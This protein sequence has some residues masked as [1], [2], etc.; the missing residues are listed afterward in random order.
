MRRL[1]EGYV[2]SR[3]AFIRINTIIRQ[4]GKAYLVLFSKVDKRPQTFEL[5]KNVIA[6]KET[7]CEPKRNLPTISF[8]LIL[9]DT[10]ILMTFPRNNN[11]YRSPHRTDL[12]FLDIMRIP[13]VI[14]GRSSSHIF[15]KTSKELIRMPEECMHAPQ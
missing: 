8:W 12:N 7:T 2:Y 15:V 4:L 3:A 13:S 14:Y 5:V 1:F 6:D 10:G 11:S 9:Y